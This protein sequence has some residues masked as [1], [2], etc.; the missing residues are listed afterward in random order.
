M[1][2]IS[3][4]GV[5]SGIDTKTIVNALVASEIDPQ[6]Q[7]LAT[8]KSTLDAQLS[9]FGR[10]K[11]ALSEFQTTLNNLKS[12]DRFQVRSANVGNE[13]RFT[14][15]ANRNAQPGEYEVRVE[16][17]ATSQR[18]M[19]ADGAFASRDSIVGN[20]TINIGT[21]GSFDPAL[22][23]GFSV[24][25]D[26]PD[27]TL[28]DIRRAINNAEGNDSVTASIVNVDDGSGG[29]QA[30]LILTATETGT[31]N[32]LTLD[33][34]E[35]TSPGLSALS[36]S[37]LEVS[38]APEDARIQVNGLTV[39][40]SS[41]EISD[42]I[43]GVTLNLNSADIDEEVSLSIGTDNS[44]IE[45]N[46]QGFVDAYNKLQNVIRDLASKEDSGLRGDSTVRNL[47]SQLRTLTSGPVAGLDAQSS[48]L[49]QVGVSIDKDGRMS[50]DKSALNESLQSNFNSVADLFASSDG[51]ASRLDN[52]IKPYSQAGGLLDNRT[53]GVNSRLRQLADRQDRLDMR[54]ENLFNR[55][56]RQFNAMD[57]MVAQMNS[58][59]AFLTAQLA[60]MQSF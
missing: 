29:T 38:R 47:S 45:K 36:S 21:G 14:A 42:V 15:T 6:R 3:F 55:L 12:P 59:G 50:L 11:S 43:Q 32:A 23:N 60:N 52:F 44:A 33:V 9:G 51:V 24:N 2:A 8:R 57:S 30:R 18:L 39:T 17:L 56:S 58:N 10:L 25:I 19:T 48:I 35:G 27:A 13:D 37:N 54:E 4:S 53:E 22:G 46:V 5:G 31:A 41:N 40:R 1:S 7:Q 16:Q 49:A 26:N 34:V 20:G 28:D